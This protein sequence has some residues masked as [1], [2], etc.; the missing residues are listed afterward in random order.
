[1]LDAV[2]AAALQHVHRADDVAVDVGVRVLD[3]VTH[4]GL[5]GEVH[6][7][8]HTGACK[9]CGHRRTILQR[10]TVATEPRVR[11]QLRESR[12]LQTDV[13]VVVDVVHTDDLVTA[14]K[15]AAGDVESDEAG[16]AGNHDF[17]SYYPEWFMTVAQSI[18]EISDGGAALMRCQSCLC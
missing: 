18:G 3:G 17:H 12:L 5:G 7:A 11:G 15:Q 4:T 1:V 8:L 10:V 13:I 2:V 14:R 9:Q 16:G 6:H